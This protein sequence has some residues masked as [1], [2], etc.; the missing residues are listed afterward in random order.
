FGVGGAGT[1]AT[2]VK[3]PDGAS[4]LVQAG[5]AVRRSTVLAVIRR[6][7]YATKFEELQGMRT[8]LKA[9]VAKARLDLERAEGL[10]KDRAISQTGDDA[11]KGRYD[12]LVGEE[13]GGG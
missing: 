1:S 8:G 13:K 2:R 10:L 11:S 3:Q 6:S 12:A 5:D 7:D 4:R 9:S